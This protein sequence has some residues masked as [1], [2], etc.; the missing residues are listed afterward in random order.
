MDAEK[1]P[2]EAEETQ[3]SV[4]PAETIAREGG[5]KPE[6]EW[7][8]DDP[9]KPNQ[10]MS[11]ELF[12]ERGVWIERYKNQDKRIK[13]ME[14]SFEDRLSNVNRLH[15]QQLEVQ[16]SE[17]VRK[18]DD[19]IDLADRETANK[20]QNDIDRLE[21]IP[22]QVR[23]PTQTLLDQWNTDNPWIYQSGP[24]TAYAQSQLNTYTTQGMSIENSLKAMEADIAREFPAMNRNRTSEPIPEGGSPPGKK[25]AP[26]KLHW[27]DLTSEEI[28]WYKA[29]PGA[30]KNESEYL[31]AVSDDR[32]NK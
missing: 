15:N 10:F 19:A 30:W 29:M 6:E 25:S 20:I 26:R 28:K 14:V 7:A 17:L 32:G 12:N 21:P 27:S 5:W 24:K 13:E 3:E 18:R 23:A 1:Q 31:Q 4:N 2:E 16:K 11:V 9:K 22:E 8:S